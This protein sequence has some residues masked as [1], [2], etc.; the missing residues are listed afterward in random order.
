[1]NVCSIYKD[2]ICILLYLITDNCNLNIAKLVIVIL[3]K[4][5]HDQKILIAR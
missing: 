5:H 3:Q 1:M 2:L 4:I